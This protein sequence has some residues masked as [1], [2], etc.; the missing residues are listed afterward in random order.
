MGSGLGGISGS[1]GGLL[2][3]S[4]KQTMQNLNDRLANYLDKVRALEEANTDLETKIE[5]WYSKHGSGRGGSRRDY[6]KYYPV[7][8]DLKNQ[9]G[10]RSC[11]PVTCLSLL[12]R[13]YTLMEFTPLRVCMCVCMRMQRR[14]RR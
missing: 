3:G 12:F 14:C 8:E 5:Q 7:I 11:A 10:L 9:V 2:S 1:D 4:E 13:S 6:S